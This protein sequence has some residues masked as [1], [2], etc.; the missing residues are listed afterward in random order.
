MIRGEMRLVKVSAEMHVPHQ[1]GT[2]SDRGAD[3]GGGVVRELWTRRVFVVPVQH[4]FGLGCISITD[5]PGRS[6]KA[7]ARQ[8]GYP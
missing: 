4:H 6:V 2:K 1:G 8:V 3:Q 5:P 7:H